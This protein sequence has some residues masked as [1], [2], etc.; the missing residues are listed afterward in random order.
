MCIRDREN[1]YD[2]YAVHVGDLVLAAKSATCAAWSSRSTMTVVWAL[3]AQKSSSSASVVWLAA[4]GRPQEPL[5]VDGEQQVHGVGPGAPASPKRLLAR[6]S[7]GRQELAH[8]G[9]GRSRRS[10]DRPGPRTGPP[11]PRDLGPLMSFSKDA[12]EAI[13]PIRKA[14]DE[15]PLLTGMENGTLPRDTFV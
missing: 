13:A 8:R 12:W 1:R 4:A 10:R 2:V 6:G 15:L 9:A 14:I 5:V 3:R 7:A 11:F